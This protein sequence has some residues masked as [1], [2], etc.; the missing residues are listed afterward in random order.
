[1]TILHIILRTTDEEFDSITKALVFWN[2]YNL[3]AI[4]GMTSS[5]LDPIHII[6]T[7]SNVT[8]ITCYV[9]PQ[10]SK[11]QGHF[12]HHMENIVKCWHVLY[13][14]WYQHNHF[15]NE[16]GGDHFINVHDRQ[17]QSCLYLQSRLPSSPYGNQIL[18]KVLNCQR[19]V[20]KSFEAQH[21]S[22]SEITV[23]LSGQ[24]PAERDIRWFYS[25]SEASAFRQQ[26]L[27]DLKSPF[28]AD[29]F[30]R[31]I[32]IGFIQRK[33][34]RAVLNLEAIVNAT[35]NRSML[36]SMNSQYG[37]PPSSTSWRIEKS[38]VYLEDLSLERQAKFF[39]S[40][41]IIVTPHGA[42][43]INAA[44][45]FPGSVVLE[46]FPSMYACMLYY[47]M[48]VEQVGGHYLYWYNGTT[49]VDENGTVSTTSHRVPSDST[50][51][52]KGDFDRYK[53]EFQT[54]KQ[55]SMEPPLFEI[56]ALIDQGIQHVF[57]AYLRRGLSL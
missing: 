16:E 1:L 39:A 20:D 19:R 18:E 11:W 29:A 7:A 42:G 51:L 4:G 28:A 12:P 34:S 25:V 15:I 23:A 55:A 10:I 37:G 8:S 56:M 40:N 27:P 22:P 17:N 3:P 31:T 6:P 35:H 9:P 21:R 46:I 50:S 13:Q 24:V 43:T 54:L 48:L 38:V 47:Q 36:P 32:R 49:T 26:L 45:L 44:F 14:E 41:H 30:S 5:A 57:D 2:S 53:S 33:S 52:W